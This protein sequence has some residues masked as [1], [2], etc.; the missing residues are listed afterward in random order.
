[1]AVF[2][3]YTGS[4][5]LT[6]AVKTFRAGEVIAPRKGG[7]KSGLQRARRSRKGTG[8]DPMERATEK[9]TARKGKGETVG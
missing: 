3:L 9:K 2:L 4:C 7:G 8:G 6:P 1:M 5:L